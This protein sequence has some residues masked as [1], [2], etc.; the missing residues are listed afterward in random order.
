MLDH[1][2]RRTSIQCL[3]QTRAAPDESI[4][5]DRAHLD[6][7]KPRRDPRLHALSVKGRVRVRASTSSYLQHWSA[8]TSLQPNAYEADPSEDSGFQ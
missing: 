5:A 6:V 2:D 3:S 1:L 4:Q 7:R 8:N